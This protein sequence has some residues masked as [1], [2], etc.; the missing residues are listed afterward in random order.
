MFFLVAQKSSSLPYIYI[1]LR[2]YD[3]HSCRLVSFLDKLKI[4]RLLFLF[5]FL[6]K[7]YLYICCVF[8]FCFL[9]VCLL[10]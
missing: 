10:D 3:L 4:N 1:T 2:T 5:L 8:V 6:C 9:F 7:I